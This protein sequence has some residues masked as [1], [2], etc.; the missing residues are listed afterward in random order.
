MPDFDGLIVDSI[1]HKAD[2]D[3]E[4]LEQWLKIADDPHLQLE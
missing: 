3:N 1:N 2:A 4:G